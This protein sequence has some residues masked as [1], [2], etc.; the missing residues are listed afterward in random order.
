MESTKFARW[1]SAVEAEDS[2]AA[3]EEAARVTYVLE[4]SPSL[5]DKQSQSLL[6]SEEM[7]Q[8]TDLQPLYKIRRPAPIHRSARLFQPLA[9]RA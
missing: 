6:E 8:L 2:P 3:M 5:R 1:L 7:V 4:N 9:D